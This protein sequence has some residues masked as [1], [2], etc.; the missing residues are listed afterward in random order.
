MSSGVVPSRHI[1]FATPFRG[2][3]PRLLSLRS[4]LPSRQLA[5]QSYT[6]IIHPN[7]FYLDNLCCLRRHFFLSAQ[8]FFIITE[9]FFSVCLIFFVTNFLTHVTNFVICVTNFVT[10][11]I[12]YD[13][14]KCQQANKKYLGKS[15]KYKGENK[16][17]LSEKEFFLGQIVPKLRKKRC[18]LMQFS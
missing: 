3:R 16:N 7:S 13:R 9:I 15:E 14:K 5:L 4:V 17:N 11:T 10:K 8:T 2:L 1:F 18:A 6:Y 12:L